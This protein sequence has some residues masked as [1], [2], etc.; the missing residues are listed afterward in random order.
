MLSIKYFKELFSYA[1]KHTKN[2]PYLLQELAFITKNTMF[3]SVML[4]DHYIGRLLKLLVAISAAKKILEIGTYT[5]YATLSMAEALPI[6][7][8]II[9]CEIDP[10]AIK[11]ANKFFNLS[12]HG[13][14]ITLMPG[15]ALDTIKTIEHPL[16]LVFIDADKANYK[17]Y[18]EQVLPKLKSGGLIIID[19]AFWGGEVLN[20]ISTQAKTIDQL[21]K[22]IFNCNQVENILLNIRDGVNIVRKK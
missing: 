3:G 1:A 7:G 9:T 16:D 20:A 10:T 15:P 19:N 14:K 8:H 11:M 13:H 17:N 22:Q 6:D 5:G 2:A 12:P 18:Y 21:N 4:S